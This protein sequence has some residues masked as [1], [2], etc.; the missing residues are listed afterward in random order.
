[1]I[2]LPDNIIVNT[3]QKVN[4][5]KEFEIVSSK[6]VTEHTYQRLTAKYNNSGAFTMLISEVFNQEY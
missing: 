3:P 1:M 6:L 4:I 2:F 5:G